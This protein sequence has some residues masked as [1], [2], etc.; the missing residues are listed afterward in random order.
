MECKKD[1]SLILSA[2]AMVTALQTAIIVLLVVVGVV[3]KYNRRKT[4]PRCPDTATGPV[5]MGGQLYEAV[6]PAEGVVANKESLRARV[7]EEP[8]DFELNSSYAA[9]FK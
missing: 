4:T 6:G 1:P 2:I 9:H 3:S 7:E 5:E 8:I